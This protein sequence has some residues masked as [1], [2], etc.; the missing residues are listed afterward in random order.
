MV[1]SIAQMALKP[2]LMPLVFIQSAEDAQIHSIRIMTPWLLPMMA[3]VLVWLFLGA[4][5]KRRP[6]TMQW[7]HMTM[8]LVRL[9]LERLAW[10]TSMTTDS[11]PLLICSRS[12]PYSVYPVIDSGSEI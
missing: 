7:P 10:E 6:I 5:T 8:D 3:H 11:S 2:L 12:Y 4:R 1:E 9:R